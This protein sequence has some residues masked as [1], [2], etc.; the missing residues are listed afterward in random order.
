MTEEEGRIGRGPGPGPEG[1][2]LSWGSSALGADLG[3]M[4]VVIVRV[5]VGVGGLYLG[6]DARRV[7][8]ECCGIRETVEALSVRV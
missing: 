2:L 6:A 5:V 3:G 7:L 8:R 1:V 4:V